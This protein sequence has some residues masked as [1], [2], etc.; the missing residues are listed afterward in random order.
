MSVNVECIS[1]TLMRTINPIDKNCNRL[2]FT[3][4]RKIAIIPIAI[5]LIISLSVVLNS[6][7]FGIIND[8]YAQAQ[9]KVDIPSSQNKITIQQIS[10][11]FAPLT[12]SNFNQLKVLVNYQTNDQSL[13]NTPMKGTMKVFLSDGTPLKT[14]SIQKGYIVGQSGV[15]QFATSFTDKSI[16]KVKAEVY[17]TNTQGSEKVSN[18]ITIN[19]SLEK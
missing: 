17:L 9:Q 13:V 12:D 2:L 10:A 7:N 19:S 5:T 18:T 3:P 14:S 15:I 4:N 16:Q 6:E 11:K 1:N 8:V